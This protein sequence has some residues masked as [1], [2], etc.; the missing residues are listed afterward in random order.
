MFAREGFFALYNSHDV[1]RNAK[2]MYIETVDC[3]TVRLKHKES[4]QGAI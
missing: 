2:T 1:Q 3:I 4:K